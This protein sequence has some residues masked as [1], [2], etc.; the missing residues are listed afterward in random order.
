MRGAGEVENWVEYGRDGF[1]GCDLM[2]G[3][4]LEFI[5]GELSGKT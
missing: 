1:Y 2:K 3:M 4:E 5:V